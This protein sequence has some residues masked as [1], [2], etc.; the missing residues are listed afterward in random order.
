MK[1]KLGLGFMLACLSLPAWA[2]V[3]GGGG[4]RSSSSSS[5]TS[6]PTA[7]PAKAESKPAAKATKKAD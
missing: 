7:A 6:T 5:S 4:Y 3:G 2:R 1:A